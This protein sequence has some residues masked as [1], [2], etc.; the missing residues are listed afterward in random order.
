M[1]EDGG[2][3]MSIRGPNIDVGFGRRGKLNPKVSINMLER[4]IQNGGWCDCLMELDTLF[5]KLEVSLLGTVA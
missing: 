3:R 4:Q 5:T 1:V 2:L